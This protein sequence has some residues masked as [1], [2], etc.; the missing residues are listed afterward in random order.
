MRTREAEQVIAQYIADH[1]KDG[2]AVLEVSFTLLTPKG[3][4]RQQ[5]RRVREWIRSASDF[6]VSVRASRPLWGRTWRVHLVGWGG[7]ICS[8]LFEGSDL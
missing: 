7:G 8:W 5:R 4:S 6:G 3:A 1:G 2:T